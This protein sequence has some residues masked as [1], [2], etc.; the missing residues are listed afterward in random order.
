M[1]DD[2]ERTGGGETVVLCQQAPGLEP[3]DTIQNEAVTDSDP[4]DP[5]KATAYTAHN[6][7]S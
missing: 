4:A 6:R 2:E 3:K 1:R 7:V 5:F